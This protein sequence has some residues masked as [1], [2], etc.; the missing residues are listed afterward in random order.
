MHK[1][2]LKLTSWNA[3]G[4]CCPHKQSELRNYCA[5]VKPDIVLVQETFFSNTNNKI[6]V[7]GYV[8]I[9]N[10]RV[11]FGGG[12]LILIKRSVQFEIYN[13]RADEPIEL[14]SVKIC[15]SGMPLIIS[16]IYIPK[17]SPTT[18]CA[19]KKCFCLPNHIVIGDWNA[20]HTSWSTENNQ[21]G[22][23]LFDI[24]PFNGYAL[25]APT[26]DTYI[27]P[28]G[29][30]STIDFIVSNSACDF[31]IP[32]V[33]DLLFSDHRAITTTI[34][35]APN[36][37]TE[38]IFDYEKADWPLFKAIVNEHIAPI[39]EMLSCN[40]CE[41]NTI[42][43]DDNAATKLNEWC[44]SL[45][46]AII[47][48][49]E[50]AIPK[51]VVRIREYVMSNTTKMLI[52]QKNKTQRQYIA[53]RDPNEKRTLRG[54]INNFKSLIKI[55]ANKDR[56]ENWRRLIQRT[57]NDVKLFWRS[58]RWMKNRNQNPTSSFQ[59]ADGPTNDPQLIVN[60]IADHFEK[61]HTTH[62]R[63]ANSF[64]RKIERNYEK[65]LQGREAG[66]SDLLRAADVISAISRQK[67]RKAP[68]RDGIN[69]QLLKNLPAAAIDNLTA[70]FNSCIKCGHWPEPLKRAIVVPIPKS[71]LPANLPSSLRPISLL[72]TINKTFECIILDQLKEHS[73]SNN[74][75]PDHQYGF[76]AG[77]SAAHQAT[78]LSATLRAN[79]SNKLSTGVVCL[80]ISKAFDS[81]W[82]A[83]LIH[84]LKERLLAPHL[85]KLMASFC[86]GRTFQVKFADCLSVEKPI[87]AGTPQGSLISPWAYAVYT[88]DIPCPANS[89]LYTYA[90]DTA[91]VCSAKQNRTVKSRLTKAI[92]QINK[93]FDRWHI[94]ANIDKTQFLFAPFN[95]RKVRKTPPILSIGQ[96][97]IEASDTIKYLGVTFDK[98]LKYTPHVEKLKKK[99][100]AAHRLLHPH[101][102]GP[103]LNTRNRKLLIK[104]VIRP[105]LL[106]GIGA[107]S[108]VC[109]TSRI[110]LRRTFS[111]ISKNILRWPMY[112]ATTQLYSHI[113]TNLIEDIVAT[114]TRHVFTN[115]D[116]TK[117][118][119]LHALRTAMTRAWPSLLDP[120]LGQNG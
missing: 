102:I 62:T 83:G 61:S 109:R 9:K 82:H 119:N 81:V 5:T 101:T 87:P 73:S 67:P 91:I 100:I 55:H 92:L 98:K 112:S 4:L 113:D 34:T 18:I 89:S 118:P 2:N 88:A 103:Q 106:H 95:F 20:K 14:Q 54:I 6:Y 33:D 7:P 120:P 1:L 85:V 94:K 66:P 76:R 79:K 10:N 65:I 71:G 86:Y 93:F 96:Q 108:E 69:V 114:A 15:L 105:M 27:N 37:N 64:D 111:K 72:S 49:R 12:L 32:T 31:T 78:R 47:G 75:I 46:E 19:I 115:I 3:R 41:H 50:A 44:D 74:I 39:Y 52:A 107:W 13:L 28:N 38:S 35:C 70:L 77:H 53:S 56:N 8:P 110:A 22:V 48:A 25:F 116:T 68:G 11:A 99:L 40:E 17:Y 24:L 26:A 51:N 30:N 43:Y 104:Q 58:L 23:K 45:T 29:I 117:T 60:A 57:N 90:D 36:E 59:L 42:I 63:P 21:L 16:N 84:K 97:T 80:D